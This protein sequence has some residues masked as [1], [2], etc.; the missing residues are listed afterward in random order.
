MIIGE[1]PLSKNPIMNRKAYICVGVRAAAWAKLGKYQH[2]CTIQYWCDPRRQDSRE[3]GPTN[4]AKEDNEPW[5]DLEG[6]HVGWDL[7]DGKGDSI[8][9]CLSDLA[10]LDDETY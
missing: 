4:F 2:L 3:G 7:D 10:A 6:N 5:S 9:H 1:K 8:H